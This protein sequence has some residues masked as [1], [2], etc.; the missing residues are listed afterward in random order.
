MQ[1]SR[2]TSPNSWSS[3]RRVGASTDSASGVFSR[4]RSVTLVHSAVASAALRSTSR[5]A[6]TVSTQPGSPQM[7][8]Q[9]CSSSVR[10]PATSQFCLCPPPAI[11]AC[12]SD[13]LSPDRAEDQFDQPGEMNRR[14]FPGDLE[15]SRVWSSRLAGLMPLSSV[16]V[17]LRTRSETSCHW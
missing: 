14:E 9:G 7:V 4:A 15:M 13:Q 6:S 5:P 1:Q 16:S 12:G 2:L 17:E 3:I 8:K 10:P 11:G